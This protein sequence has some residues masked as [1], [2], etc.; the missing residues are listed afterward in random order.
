MLRDDAR[1]LALETSGRTGSV[2]IGTSAGLVA[3]ER[4]AVDM[5]HTG[6]LMPAIDRLLQQQG[7]SA[8]SLTEVFLSI[9]PGSFTGLRVAVSIARTLAWSVQARVVAVPTMAALA[10]NALFVD[11]SAVDSAVE[12][13]SP[14]DSAGWPPAHVAMVIDA[15]RNQMFTA[16]YR[17]DKSAG[18]QFTYTELRAACLADPR[19]FLASCP[20]PVVVLGEGIPR[21]RE[22]I[23]AAGATILPESLWDGRAE[24]VFAVGLELAHA[25]CFVPA[26]ELVPL[27]IRRP[28]MEERWLAK[29]GH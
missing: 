14:P 20:K 13:S 8:D 2:A 18:S 23:E 28:E 5:R 17:L 26:R 6:Q 16:C 12:P 9:G 19:E 3:A 22:A 4:L 7:W 15:K 21:H 27:Y 29:Q 24:N 10:R 1:I 11:T 25:G